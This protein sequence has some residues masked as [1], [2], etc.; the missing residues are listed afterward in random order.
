MNTITI[1]S[2]KQI[3]NDNDRKQKLWKLYLNII[4]NIVLIKKRNA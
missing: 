4:I 3:T 2:I 1:K